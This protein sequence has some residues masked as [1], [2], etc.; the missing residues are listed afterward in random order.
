MIDK[1]IFEKSCERETEEAW[2]KQAILATSI[3]FYALKQESI[4][5]GEFFVDDEVQV[6]GAVEVLNMIKEKLKNENE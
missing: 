5:M 6:A 1:S 4:A 3:I 2:N